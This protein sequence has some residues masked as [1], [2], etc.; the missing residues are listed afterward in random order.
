VL[1]LLPAGSRDAHERYV[2]VLNDG[3]FEFDGSARGISLNG[4]TV[5]FT[6]GVRSRT[7]F[8]GTR[9]GEMQFVATLEATDGAWRIVRLEPAPGSTPP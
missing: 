7:S 8:G 4:Q 6:I 3:R 9:E 2:S 5:N 1:E